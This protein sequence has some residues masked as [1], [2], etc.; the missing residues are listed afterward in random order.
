MSTIAPYNDAPKI[1]TS[2]SLL[3]GFEFSY[4]VLHKIK[5]SPKKKKKKKVTE[6]VQIYRQPVLGRIVECLYTVDMSFLWFFIIVINFL[7]T[8]PISQQ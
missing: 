8:I 7:I 6:R 1:L 2:Y 4:E 5:K 3:C